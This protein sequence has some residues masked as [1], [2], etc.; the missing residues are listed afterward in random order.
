MKK[1]KKIIKKTESIKLTCQIHNPG[2]ETNII[3]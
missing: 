3:K 1:L 2:H